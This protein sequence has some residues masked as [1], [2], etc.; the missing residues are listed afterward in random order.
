[1]HS[2][3]FKDLSKQLIESNK[4]I[5]YNPDAAIEISAKH[6]MTV[7]TDY[8]KEVFLFQDVLPTVICD[9]AGFRI[10]AEEFI[11]ADYAINIVTVSGVVKNIEDL[12]TMIRELQ[13]CFQP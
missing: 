10:K 9:R 2:Y 12:D 1:M 6:T 8:K 3:N 4:P 7:I 11:N 5:L 13:P